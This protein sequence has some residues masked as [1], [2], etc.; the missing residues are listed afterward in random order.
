MLRVLGSQVTR[1]PVRRCDDVR[2][3]LRR[4]SD[5]RGIDDLDVQRCYGELFDDDGL[6]A[7]MTGVDVLYHCVVDARVWL[8]DP[9]A[10]FT[11][12]V[13]GLR[14]ALRGA[15]CSAETDLW[16]EHLNDLLDH[17]AIETEEV[18]APL[19]MLSNVLHLW[20]TE[21]VGALLGRVPR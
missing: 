7:A 20:E 6:R 5:T 12:N 2:V 3:L 15:L 8:R 1:R 4:T 14:R 16:R 11:T 19:L 17:F 10:L 21:D 18:R 9:G 13:E